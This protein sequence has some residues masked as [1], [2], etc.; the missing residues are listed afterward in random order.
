MKALRARRLITHVCTHSDRMVQTSSLPGSSA[1]MPVRHKRAVTVKRAGRPISVF[2]NLM[3]MASGRIPNSVSVLLSGSRARPSGYFLGRLLIRTLCGHAC[4]LII[5]LLLQNS[6]A[7]CPIFS[8]F[9][10]KSTVHS[11]LFSNNYF[12]K[13]LVRKRLAIPRVTRQSVLTSVAKDIQYFSGNDFDVD[14]E[15]PI[16]KGNF[17]SVFYGT[18]RKTGISCAIKC[19]NLEEF[20]LKCYHTEVCKFSKDWF[21]I[22]E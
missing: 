22:S 7:F 2:L 20:S 18:N 11:C 8:K 17:G 9:E 5:F 21:S 4:I 13:S 1:A 6:Y 12:C 3:K 10:R 16:A 14:W 15:A 19:P